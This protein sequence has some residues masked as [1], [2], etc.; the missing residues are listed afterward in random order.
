M[1]SLSGKI[2]ESVLYLG[3]FIGIIY[4]TPGGAYQVVQFVVGV[5][6][7]VLGI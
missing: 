1:N 3:V 6:K 7:G 4:F 5:T 2:L